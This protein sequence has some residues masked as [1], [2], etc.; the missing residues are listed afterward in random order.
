MRLLD[1][2]G[3]QTTTTDVSASRGEEL[4]DC[5]GI[6]WLTPETRFMSFLDGLTLGR[7]SESGFVLP[8]S[9]VSRCHAR[10][11]RLGPLW[12]LEDQGSK[13]GSYLHGKR[14]AR[15]PL[16][17]QRL[18][19]LG[20]WVGVVCRIPRT[21][22]PNGPLVLEPSRGFVTTVASIHRVELF[23][24]LAPTDLSL[25]LVGE[26]GTGKE[27]FARGIHELS[28]RAGSFVAVNCAAIPENVAES[29]LFGHCK[30]AFTGA[31]RD[32]EGLVRAAQGGTLFLDE[33]AD[34]PLPLQVKLLRVIEERVVMPLGSTR[35]HPVDFRLLTASQ[36]P[37]VNLVEQG[38]FRGD[39]YARVNGAE[40][41]IPS[42]RNRREEVLPLF[43]HAQKS[44]GCPKELTAAFVERLCVYEWPFNVREVVQL[45]RL[46]SVSDKQRLDANDL[47]GRFAIADESEAASSPATS[48]QDHARPRRREA[49]MLRY[50]QELARLKS[51]MEQ[52]NNLSQAARDVGIPRYRAIR[53]LAAEAEIAKPP[54]IMG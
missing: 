48:D 1:T 54:M 50:S 13:N 38:L 10:I 7:E 43:R 2:D 20:D 42:L 45:A 31:V 44:I 30:G 26:T 32:S 8:D 5:L 52:T 35:P 6:L 12:V 49:W 41:A 53:L 47:P 4:P 51:A 24:A 29:V 25:V 9:K 36:V 16:E 37:L 19:R 15:A 22:N 34:L 11:G 27:V 17:E 18:V 39:L 40:V 46:L 21:A 14:I 28:Q 23:Q 33:I 3:Q